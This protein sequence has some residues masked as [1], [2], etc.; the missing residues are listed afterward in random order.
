MII[1]M[2][3]YK[4]NYNKLLTNFENNFKIIASSNSFHP[5]III[6]YTTISTFTCVFT[7]KNLNL[8]ILINN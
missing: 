4:Y 5:I 7:S 3:I 2:N 1:L 8:N 6:F